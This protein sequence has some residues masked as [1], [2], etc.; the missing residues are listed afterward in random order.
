MMSAH[1]QRPPFSGLSISHSCQ[2]KYP[3]THWCK[4]E[5]DELL[6]KASRTPDPEERLAVYRQAMKW[7]TEEGGDVFEGKFF[8]VAA[9]R[10]N[11][12]GYT[13]HVQISRFDLRKVTCTR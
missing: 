1:N 9:S 2:S 12:S 11:C 6:L 10:A 5:Y 8:T 13:P 7:I 4:P 3:E